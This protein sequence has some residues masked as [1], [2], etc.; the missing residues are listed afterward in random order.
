MLGQAHAC[1]VREAV[2]ACASAQKHARASACLCALRVCTWPEK[3]SL[4]RQ[5]SAVEGE[6]ARARGEEVHLTRA[7][8]HAQIE[9][10]VLR[11][12]A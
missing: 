6:C 5:C 9:R 1:V 12:N 7:E 11:T 4:E 8:M 3:G 2:A 10:S